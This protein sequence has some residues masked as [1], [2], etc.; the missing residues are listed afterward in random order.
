MYKSPSKKTRF[1]LRADDNKIVAI[2]AAYKTHAGCISGIKN[3]QKNSGSRV[4]DLTKA[5]G[6]KIPNPKYQIYKEPS[7][8]FRFRLKAAN[9][10]IIAVGEKCESKADCFRGIEVVKKSSDA[11]VEDRFSRKKSLESE[12]TPKSKIQPE[13][14]QVETNPEA[15]LIEE[16]DESL[17]PAAPILSAK[18]SVSENNGPFET[19][20]ELSFT[21]LNFVKGDKVVLQGN[22]RTTTGQ[23]ISGAK[24]CILARNRSILG[25]DYLAFGYTLEDG[26][27]IINWKA[28]RLSWRKETGEIYASFVGNEKAKASKSK[29]QAIVIK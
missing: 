13:P 28:R 8:V 27:F 5:G 10:D 9:G 19:S 16:E 2:G 22:L 23:G 7:G 25:D 21:Q 29:I 11:R 18:K 1:R 15:A 4:E 24:I 12:V 20:L 26:S 6:P 14:E 3:V 17:S